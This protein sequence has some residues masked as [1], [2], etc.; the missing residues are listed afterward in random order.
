MQRKV[1]LFIN[2]A[3]GEFVLKGLKKNKIFID[4]IFS[5]KDIK[6]DHKEIKKKTTLN[7]NYIFIFVG[8]N[9]IISKSLL[10]T[11]K[12]GCFNC[13]AGKLPKY[14]GTSIIPWQIINGEKSGECNILKMTEDIDDGKIY[15]KEKYK[16]LNSD[17]ATTI[18]DKCNLIFLKQ[19]IKL[20]R[21]FKNKKIFVF[22]SQKNS[23]KNIIWTKR[24]PKDGKIDWSNKSKDIYNFVR[25][26][27]EPYPG[28]FTFTEKTNKK[29]II[30]KCREYQKESIKGIA[31]RI[32]KIFDDSFIVCT[33]DSSIE[34][35]KLRN[36]TIKSLIISGKIFVG[37]DLF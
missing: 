29:L 24:K 4:N 5:Q 21:N 16:I 31:G 9:Q 6:K 37:L 28:A 25:A 17:N 22:K 7:D 12:S 10:K 11:P 19:I 30:D 3:R 32:V 1:A 33:M 20:I 8:I 23:T 27:N 35:L 34:I 14:R 18:S 26:L 2:G 36:Q 13:H 15:L